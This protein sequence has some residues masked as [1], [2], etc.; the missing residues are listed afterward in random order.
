[1][2]DIKRTMP[3]G[4]MNMPEQGMDQPQQYMAQPPVAPK[5]SGWGGKIIAI[6]VVIVVILIGLFLVSKYTNWNILN[7]NKESAGA[8]GW[9]AVFLTNGQV[10]FGQVTKENDKIIVLADIYYL[11]V[12]Q[13]PQP[14][15]EGQA[16]AQAN[17]NLS[18]VKLGNELHG[19]KDAMKINMSQV[20][21]TEELK[22]DSKV[23]DAI[24]RYKADQKK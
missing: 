14:A 13:S 4:G 17:S 5:K 24:V 21:F 11:Q 3:M 23:V 2:S 19:P 15:P 9:Q 22:S 1:M 8:T 10:Y 16:A 7:V 18:L 12:A 6:V 20:L